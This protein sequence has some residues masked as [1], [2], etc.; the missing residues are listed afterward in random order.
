MRLLTTP[1]VKLMKISLKNPKTQQIKPNSKVL[2]S[3]KRLQ[4]LLRSTHTHS[5]RTRMTFTA[6]SWAYGAA[7][8]K[9]KRLPLPMRSPRTGTRKV[10]NRTRKFRVS[11]QRKTRRT[12][13]TTR[14]LGSDPSSTQNIAPRA[15]TYSKKSLNSSRFTR[16]VLL[17][18]K[19]PRIE[20]TH[21][22][23]VRLTR[24]SRL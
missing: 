9:R 6:C 7:N 16:G 18:N 13:R 21:F 14:S 2:R 24:S 22:P 11:L 4:P 17:S 20:K 1:K 10:R 8:E 5:S 23:T 15:Q 3:P 12:P 19:L